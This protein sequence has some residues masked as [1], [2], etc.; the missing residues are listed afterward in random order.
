MT[1]LALLTMRSGDTNVAR[2]FI[3]MPVYGMNRRTV[4]TS[5]A[6]RPAPFPTQCLKR[7]P[8]M[9][10]RRMVTRPNPPRSWIS[11]AIAHLDCK[12]EKE[13]QAKICVKI[14]VPEER[15]VIGSIKV[16]F[17]SDQKDYLGYKQ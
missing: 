17:M 10:M 7:P 6:C 8:R 11:C 15:M 12:A 4:S 3:E 1:K 5:L 16:A 13:W 9:T 14:K 2:L